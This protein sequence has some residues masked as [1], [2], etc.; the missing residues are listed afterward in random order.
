MAC[1]QTLTCSFSRHGV[2]SVH[3]RVWSYITVGNAR[4]YPQSQR[5]RIAVTL[6][7][8]DC[9]KPK[10]Q[11]KVNYV[12][13]AFCARSG[14]SLPKKDSVHICTGRRESF[15]GAETYAWNQLGSIH[16]Y[17]NEYMA[18]AH[19]LQVAMGVERSTN[20]PKASQQRLFKLPV[21]RWPVLRWPV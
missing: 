5:G 8:M 16:F 10:Y 15:P 14:G 7:G 18:S 6:K 12:R 17:F 13:R 9:N 1:D 2:V 21:L 11:S 20:Q 4:R 3:K 19:H